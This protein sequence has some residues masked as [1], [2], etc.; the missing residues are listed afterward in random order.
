M[1]R[2]FNRYE[3]KYILTH[4][5][6]LRVAKDLEGF[7]DVDNYAGAGGIYRVSSLY[8]DSPD[9][10][11]YRNKIDGIKYR[12][13]L[14][15]RIYKDSDL[16]FGFVEIKQRINRTV[17]KRRIHLP[18][19]EAIALCSGEDI[20]LDR[21]DDFDR[22]TASEVLFLV[23]A[24]GMKPKC[25][26]SYHRRAFEGSRYDHG[27]RITFDKH[28]KYRIHELDITSEC[29]DRFFLPPDIVVMEIKANEKVPI[30]LTSLLGAHEC[31]LRRVSKY[32]IGISQGL[33]MLRDS[34]A[35]QL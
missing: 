33:T 6:H 20:G 1:I 17:Q 11:C 35:Y 22:D 23:K 30:W 9:L 29:R 2:K 21:L 8:F 27:L 18:M 12:R 32:C 25:V 13:K 5:E 3:L 10:S 34:R 4:E 26:I 24:L 14:R 19:E 15:L 31:N 28:L 16:K 7:L